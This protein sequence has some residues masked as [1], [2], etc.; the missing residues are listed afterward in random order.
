MGNP[1]PPPAMRA[2]PPPVMRGETEAEHQAAVARQEARDALIHYAETGQTTVLGG[3]VEH[4]P[5]EPNV[6]E[7]T[8]P[9]ATDPETTD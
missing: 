7:G 3:H 1:D 6:N 8:R 5:E 4:G 9:P 2:E